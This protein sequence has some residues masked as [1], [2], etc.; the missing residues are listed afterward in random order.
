MTTSTHRGFRIALPFTGLVMPLLLVSLSHAATLDT[1]PAYDGTL[2]IVK[3]CCSISNLSPTKTLSIN[4]SLSGVIDLNGNNTN[5][6]A[7]FTN[8][9]VSPLATSTLCA[10]ILGQYRP[11]RCHFVFTGVKKSQARACLFSDH[12]GSLSAY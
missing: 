1:P 11:V 7:T 2:D 10:N 12:T 5:G 4:A 3:I 6:N 8:T 9:E